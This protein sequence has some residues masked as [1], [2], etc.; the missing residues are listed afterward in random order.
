MREAQPGFR[1]RLDYAYEI[2]LARKPSERETERMARY[3][4]QQ[5]GHLQQNVK[6]AEGLFPNHVESVTETEAAA[7][8]GVGR[9]LLNL[10][11]FMNRE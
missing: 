10:D 2:A 7:W 5:I 8:V 6:E 1:H 11:E 9:V 3:Y 4:D